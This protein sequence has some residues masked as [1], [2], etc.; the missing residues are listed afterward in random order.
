MRDLLLTRWTDL[1]DKLV[2]LTEDFP[3]EQYDALPADGVR[4]FA[5][6]VRHLAFWNSYAGAVL[7]GESPDGAANTLSAAD[8]PDKP[9]LVRVLRESVDS[10]ATALRATDTVSLPVADTMVS[11]IQHSAEHY[12]QLVLYCRVNGII[13]PLSR[14]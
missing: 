4:T 12:G 5:E 10:V 8:Y 13:P 14:G 6:Q 11:F 9:A 2:V 3:R 1:G 7:R